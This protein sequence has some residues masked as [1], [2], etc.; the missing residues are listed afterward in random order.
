MSDLLLPP[1]VTGGGRARSRSGASRRSSSKRSSS[2]TGSVR[3]VAV[4]DDFDHYFKVFVLGDAAI[5]K[6]AAFNRFF[7]M[8]LFESTH[9]PTKQVDHKTRMVEVKDASTNETF[10]IKTDLWYVSISVLT[11]FSRRH[12]WCLAL[13]LVPSGCLMTGYL[14]LYTLSNLTLSPSTPTLPF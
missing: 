7:G 2:P 13:S 8:T 9:K 5:G 3:S 1:T 10:R 11:F 12:K 6:T 4:E 14:V